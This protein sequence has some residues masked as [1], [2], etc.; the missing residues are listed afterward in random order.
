MV[1]NEGCLGNCSF[2]EEHYQHSLTS[3]MCSN[4]STNKKGFSLIPQYSG[5]RDVK[6]ICLRRTNLVAYKE[7][8]DEVFDYVDIIKIG[9]RRHRVD[10]FKLIE[11][12]SDDN[13]ICHPLLQGIV[14]RGKDEEV[15][16]LKQWRKTTKNCGYQ[17]WRCDLCTKLDNIILKSDR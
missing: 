8:L 1:I 10:A 3:D 17:C 16:L 14:D 11:L 12:L 6:N 9:G 4:E 7:D 5:C 15:E 13:Y 2:W